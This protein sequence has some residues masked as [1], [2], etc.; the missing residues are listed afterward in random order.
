MEFRYDMI[1]DPLC[2]KQG[3]VPLHSDHRFY[4]TEAEQDAETS[5]FRYD[6]NGLW[7]FH[8]AENYQQ[9][10]PGFEKLD[11]SC[12]SWDYIRV[13]SHI[14]MEGYDAP[15]YV[16]TQYP[17]EGH[18]SLV[19]GQIPEDFNPVATYVKYFTLPH[20]ME[21]ERV[22]LMLEGAE[23]AVAVW[24]NGTFVGYHEDSFTHAEFEM[25]KYLCPGENKLAVQVFKWCQGSWCED[26]D[27]YRFSG[28]FRD[29]YLY[30]I[31][32]THVWDLHI[33]AIPAEDFHTAQF[34]V[35]AQVYGSGTMT[36]SLSDGCNTLYEEVQKAEGL[37]RF[38]ASIPSPRLWS[39]EDPFLYDCKITLADETGA[40]CEY[41]CEKVGF[42]L[43]QL[44]DSVMY[45]N[46]HRIVFKG[47]N[48]HEFNSLR[49]RSLLKE[50]VEE[51]LRIIKQNNINA[52]RTSH[53]PN[54]SWLYRL[55]DQY[56][57]YLMD[58]TNLESHGT[59]DVVRG[60]ED[61]A[62]IVPN[63]HAQWKNMLLE[64]ARSMY[65]RDKNHPSVLIWSCGNESYGGS[66]IYEMSQFFRKEDPTRLVHYEGIGNDR[67]YPDTSDIESQMYTPV[68]DIEEFLKIHRD[69][70]FI[71][72][73]YAHAMGNSC[74]ALH[75]YTDLAKREQ[76]YQGGFIWDFADQSILTKNR[77]G[78]D[79]FAYGGDF[80][81]RPTDYHFSGN[82]LVSGDRRLTPK[83]QEVKFLYQNIDLLVS[84]DQV[85]IRNNNSFTNTRNWECRVEVKYFGTT[86]Q[87]KVLCTD[88]APL[89]VRVYPLELQPQTRP[90]SYTIT[91]S[92]HLR[93]DECWAKAGHEIAF[94]QTC[95]E[96]AKPKSLE[97][98][99]ITVIKSKRNIGVRG[100]GFEVL[101]SL[102]KGG[103]VS[104]RYGGKELLD[105]MPKPNFWRAPTDNDLGSLMAA[106][107]GQWKLAS[108]YLDNRRIDGENVQSLPW[109]L[110]EK[111][112]SV[113]IC[114]RHWLPTAPESFC[115]LSYEVFGDG[116]VTITLQYDPVPGLSRMPEFG[117]LF[118]LKADFDCLTWYGLGPD[119]TYA[120][121]KHGAKVGL[122]RSRV[123]ENMP[124][125]LVP[126][127]CG[128]KEEVRFASVTD[129]RGRGILFESEHN[130]NF[131]F[132]A[133]PYTP[134]QLEEAA[135]PYE[136]PRIVH[137]NV[138]VAMAQMGVGGDNSWGARTHD[139]YLIP[140][141][142]KLCFTFSFR[143]I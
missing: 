132:S 136:L 36:V 58:E 108:L 124:P 64:R 25:T 10:V 89:G 50:D 129:T 80:D 13:P 21:A 116:K 123:H 138:R 52:I 97:Q 137:T 73:E 81:D 72:C 8:Y 59:W 127:E 90:G 102:T 88:V 71:C 46:G 100:E 78:E 4:R 6:L 12:K 41:I 111:E 60:P 117:V 95:Y 61:V 106:R 62:N 109:H 17:W 32:V 92:F 120:D 65:E 3:C 45:L 24:L 107:Y 30:S 43:F 28:L 135:H 27:F 20:T 49:G 31:P 121:R 99:P 74:G 134:H 53:Y 87:R 1:V 70:P 83:M 128:N 115:D 67:R 126:Q 35:D 16:N 139:E 34:S 133:L 130:R 113:L 5:S 40:E 23:S 143:G 105:A 112:H 101:F 63:D 37:I 19:P 85:E 44:K 125:Y 42:R 141:D 57:L 75:K 114:M 96:I 68:K 48:R 39:C 55:C 38:A 110:E 122:Y 51:D 131:C 14:Q 9:I 79:Y 7:R 29:V 82:G 2:Y 118:Q 84:Q 76:L 56:G 47:V 54:A 33:Q 104:Y 22:F 26:Q 93:N 11:Y 94:G 119:D 69:K 91:V 98:S 18:E 15:Q 140:K 86:V 103:L 66:V 142:Q 77:F